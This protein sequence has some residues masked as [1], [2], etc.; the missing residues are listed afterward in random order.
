[1]Q[2]IVTG[3]A[4]M[5]GSGVVRYLNDLGFSHLLLVDDLKMGEKWKNLVGKQFVDLISKHQ[6]LS[7]LQ[8]REG[9]IDAIVH[10]AGSIVV[11]NSV[12]A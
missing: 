8:G 10:S 6:L 2:I 11:P 12:C 5:I 3:A 7:W 4:G 1:M 9:E